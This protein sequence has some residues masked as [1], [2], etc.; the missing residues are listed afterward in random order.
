[1]P[2]TEGQ[3]YAFAAMTPIITG[4]TEGVIHAA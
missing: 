2:N 4:N 3:S 1:M